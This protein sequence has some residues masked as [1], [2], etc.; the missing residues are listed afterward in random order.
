MG[1]TENA[2]YGILIA[3]VT[4]VGD[5]DVIDESVH[6]AIKATTQMFVFTKQFVVQNTGEVFI[7][8]TH[9]LSI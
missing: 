2:F 7:Q 5:G 6:D 1:L 9:Q 8:Q 3:E 4:Q